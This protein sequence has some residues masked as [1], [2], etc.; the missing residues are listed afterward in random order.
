MNIIRV[1]SSVPLR[2]GVFEAPSLRE[3]ALLRKSA[4][5][6]HVD[7][8]IYDIQQRG[9]DGKCRTPL[10]SYRS[11]LSAAGSGRYALLLT[12]ARRYYS[13]VAVDL[14]QTK[15]RCH[16]PRRIPRRCA[17]MSALT[18]RSPGGSRAIFPSPICGYS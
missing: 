8:Q 15:P 11:L 1:L 3:R 16:P 9:K 18:Q 10:N 12:R 14:P 17:T 2:S 7:R 5:G 13:R 6:D 4:S